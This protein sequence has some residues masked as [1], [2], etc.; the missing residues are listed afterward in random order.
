MSL[1]TDEQNTCFEVLEQTNR[2]ILIEALAGTGKTTTIIEMGRRF[3][4]APERKYAAIMYMTY[5]KRMKEELQ[6]KV[7]GVGTATSF[8]SFGYSLIKQEW[9]SVRF[10]SNWG[11]V[12]YIRKRFP[13]VSA[14]ASGIRQVLLTCMNKGIA[15]DECESI[16]QAALVHFA[17]QADV[18]KAKRLEA[19]EV[20]A[21]MLAV[22]STRSWCEHKG[23]EFEHCCYLPFLHA[24]EPHYKAALGCIDESQ[25]MNATQAY[26]ALSCAHRLVFVGDR[27]Q[28]IYRWRGAM[29]AVMDYVKAETDAVECSLTRSFRCAVKVAAE[30]RRYVPAFRA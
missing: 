21:E 10:A 15:P 4:S 11:L 6:T 16:R 27:N 13:G 7:S 19:A 8:H 28:A 30:A 3:R 24:W 23:I 20:A 22:L 26:L 1:W 2:H 9:P 14:L 5:N 12:N 17:D 25:D 18:P 29:N